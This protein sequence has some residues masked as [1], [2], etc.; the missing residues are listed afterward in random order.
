MNDQLETKPSIWERSTLVRFFRWLFSW[1]GIRRVLIVLAWSATIIGLL[2]GE[3][4][5]RG[6][7]AWNQYRQATEAR[8]VS[9]DYRTY[10][11]K[12]VPDDQNFAATPFLKSFLQTSGDILTNDLYFRACNHI[13]GHK[14]AKDRGRRHFTDLAAWQLAFVALQSG[15]LKQGQEFETDITDLAARAAAAPS[16]LEGL[17]PDEATFEEL[18]AASTRENSRFPLAYDLENPCDIL[19][20]HLGKVKQIEER[21]NLQACAELAAGRSDRALADVK[22]MLSLADSVKSE[23]FLISFLVRLASVQSAIQPVWEGLAE[24]RWT[25]AQLQELQARFLSYDFLAD[26]EQYLKAERASETQMADL[27]TKKGLG[28]IA[29]IESAN[30]AVEPVAKFFFYVLGR[31]EPSG[32]YYQEKLSY[33][34]LFDAQ[35]EGVLDEAARTV[36]PRKVALN[37]DEMERQGMDGTWALAAAPKVI[38]Q[39]VVIAKIFLSALRNVPAKPAAAQTAAEQAALACALERYR[40]ANGQF[41]ETLESLSP[42]FIARAPNDV[43]TGQPCKYRRTDDGQFILYSVGWNEKDDGGVPGKH[44]FDQAQGDWVW[45]YPAK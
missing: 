44:L 8:G 1:R 43:F 38:L 31:V 12:P 33:N 14:I 34:R 7:R 23:P 21:L 45:S 17:K 13:P 4:N 18:R 25:D 22:L 41:P 36:S 39:H 10:I 30:D 37:A 9:L 40:L 5:W 2:Y 16:V 24:H 32:W 27:V 26:M 29:G 42:K 19:L 11:P 35:F 6:R 3:E 20:P 15:G 28:Y